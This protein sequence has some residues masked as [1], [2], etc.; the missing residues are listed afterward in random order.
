MPIV[1]AAITPHPPILIPTI[2]KENLDKIKKTQTAMQE[3]ERILY[4]AKPECILI[5]SPHAKILPDAFTINLSPEYEANFE[6]FGDF[7]T[8]LKFK[9]DSLCVQQIRAADEVDGKVPLILISEP[10]ID[11][12]ASVPLYYLMQHLKEVSIAPISQS[13]LDYQAHLK[14]GE[15]LHH[16]INRINKR[17][18]VVA[19]GDLSHR[20]SEDAPGG[21]SPQGEKFDKKLLALIKQKDVSGIMSLDPFLVE[22]A[23]ECGL[24]SI[25][26]LFGLLNDINYQP[27]L[28]S[29]EGPFGVGYGVVNFKLG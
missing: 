1:F 25:I 15:F 21:F 27:E 28:L 10:K 7:S 2:G 24:K 16:Q 26:I 13:F 29:Y 5:I 3:L 9:S 4:V 23:G 11:H 8:K 14:F 6:E 18:A 20:L 17:I 22:E 19:S 12:G